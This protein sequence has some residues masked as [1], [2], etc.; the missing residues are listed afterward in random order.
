M[1]T[2]RVKK[3]PAWLSVITLTPGRSFTFGST[4]YIE[5]KLWDMQNTVAYKAVVAHESV[6]ARQYAKYGTFLF[7]FLYFLVLPFGWNP[8]RRDWEAEAFA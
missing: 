7:L 6:H 4:I 2:V 1:M 3:K 5:S 8:W